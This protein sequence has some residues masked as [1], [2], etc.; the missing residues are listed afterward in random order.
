MCQFCGTPVTLRLTGKNRVTD[1]PVA[2]YPTSDMAHSREVRP[3][4]HE[5]KFLVDEDVGAR[6]R[7][8]ARTHLDPDPHGGGPFGD[9]YHTASVYF[10]TDAFDV[11]YNRGSFG[12]SKYR[13]RRYGQAELVF[14]ERKMRRPAVLAKRRTLMSLS[15]LSRL[16]AFDL[17]TTWPGYWFHRRVAAR[18]LRPVCQVSYTRMARGVM[19][20][21]EPVRLTLDSHLL[22]LPATDLRFAHEGGAPILANRLILELKF[23]G[24]PPALFRRLAEDFALTPGAASKYRLGVVASGQAVPRLLGGIP[25]SATYV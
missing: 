14:L 9:E 10:D 21:G 19:R 11:F 17:E 18:K 25:S 12:R 24:A 2:P 1:E 3:Y 22:A 6:V 13:I 23:R 15:G 5:L 16:S 8:W 4:A 7:E 20:D